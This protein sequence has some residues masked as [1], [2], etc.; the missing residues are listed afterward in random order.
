MTRV[1]SRAQAETD[2]E[3]TQLAETARTARAKATYRTV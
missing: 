1:Q 3:H 2:L